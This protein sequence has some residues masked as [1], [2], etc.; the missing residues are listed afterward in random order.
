M[1]KI[2][3]LGEEVC[4]NNDLFGGDDFDSLQS[5]I[6]VIEFKIE[7]P[8]QCRSKILEARAP[9]LKSIGK[10]ENFLKKLLG[11]YDHDILSHGCLKEGAM[12][13]Q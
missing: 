3:A 2:F 8:E 9:L 11:V 1:N 13:D 5:Y 12:L 10:Y 7:V 6:F 4:K